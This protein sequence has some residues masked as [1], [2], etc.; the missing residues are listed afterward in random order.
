MALLPLLLA[1]LVLAARAPRL[2]PVV[3]APFAAEDPAARLARDAR[4]SFSADSSARARAVLDAG[5]LEVE[6]RAVAL[7]ALGGGRASGDLARLE[8]AL[9]DGKPLER[10]A[11]LF[12]LGEMGAAGMPA[13]ERALAGDSQGLEDALC[14]ALLVAGRRGAGTALAQLG[15]LARGADRLAHDAGLALAQGEPEAPDFAAM[16]EYH[17]LR[18][19]AA[20]AFGLVDGLRGPQALA[21]EL[22]AA[23]DFRARVVIA[24][25]SELAPEQLQSHLFELLLADE[26][27]EVL[28]VV[29]VKFPA[30]LARACKT[31]EW[32]PSLAAWHVVLDEIEAARAERRAQELLELAFLAAPELEPMAGLLLVRAGG[33]L[34][35]RWV[36]DQLEH[37][38]ARMRSALA[39]ACGDRGEAARIPDLADLL[40]RRPDLGIFGEGLVALAR[41]GHGPARTSLDGLLEGPPSAERTQAVRALAR[42]LHDPSLRARAEKVLRRSDLEPD[43]RLE[44]E[45]SLA[46]AGGNVERA[47]L[48][49][50]LLELG[51]LV[52]AGP[53]PGTPVAEERAADAAGTADAPAAP[54]PSASARAETRVRLVRALGRRPDPTD[55]ELLASLFPS[56]AAELDVE[57]CLVLLRQR[58][59][60]VNGLLRGSLWSDGWN[61]SVLAG[62]LIVAGGGMRALQDEL[63]AAPLTASE[64]DLRRVGFALGQWGG[65][66]AVEELG[67]TRSERDPALQGALFGALAGRAAEPEPS[68]TV[69]V[70]LS[71]DGPAEKPAKAPGEGP[72][73]R[74]KKDQ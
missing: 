64:Q 67:R 61:T 55:L 17:E 4:L 47:H 70:P 57:L 38:G 54:A 1:S 44:L 65:V 19:R 22:F 18:W 37:G 34:P 9:A 41:L 63:E 58:H 71:G 33:D 60:A 50:A 14:V 10:R 46:Q 6:A 53:E 8:S 74:R 72:K 11:A 51:S 28:R 21:A 13:L 73:K 26:R 30:E 59:A 24:A 45:L 12:A 20:R 15:T 3:Q 7:L 25:A 23:P 56:E 16:A 39:E 35:W 40:E 48:R 31:G 62:G 27:P 2:A 68:V 66:S 36:G 43:A 69:R 52:R 29:A 5:P 32:K 42:V 49:A